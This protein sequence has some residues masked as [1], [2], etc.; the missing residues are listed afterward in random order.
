M[1]I[2]AIVLIVVAASIVVGG[3]MTYTLLP[4]TLVMLRSGSAM[5]VSQG[6]LLPM[7]LRVVLALLILVL[8]VLAGVPTPWGAF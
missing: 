7:C 4:A 5:R 6:L 2:D 1:L 8:L 3:W